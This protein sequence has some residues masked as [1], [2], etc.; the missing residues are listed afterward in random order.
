MTNTDFRTNRDND[1]LRRYVAHDRLVEI[2]TDFGLS[3]ERVRQIARSLG[4]PARRTQQ[5]SER[6]IA[7]RAAKEERARLRAERAADR[8][9]RVREA[10]KL[11]GK[12]MSHARARAATGLPGTVKFKTESQW[13]RWR[14]YLPEKR[15]SAVR[16]YS[17]G[18]T[19]AATAAQLGVS[20]PFV[21]NALAKAGITPRKPG[22]V[23]RQSLAD[24]IEAL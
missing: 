4:A 9:S 11:I 6:T 15:E 10:E 3:K 1:I 18:A 17:D 8:A 19:L 13:G 5:A 2:G 23:K 20:V 12:G 21:N 14:A 7:S 24:I 22:R 16:I